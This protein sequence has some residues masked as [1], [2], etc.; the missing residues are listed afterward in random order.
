MDKGVE[1]GEDMKHY[2]ISFYRLLIFML[3]IPVIVLGL[4][5]LSSEIFLY[6]NPIYGI[7]FIYILLLDALLTKSGY[8]KNFWQIASYD[9]KHK[10]LFV[11]QITTISFLLCLLDL[12]EKYNL[13]ILFLILLLGW[14]YFSFYSLEVKEELKKKLFYK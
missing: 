10:I 12:I 14:I 3:G 6:G 11:S 1:I 9:K 8:E 5:F 2:A 7:L 4:N 13:I